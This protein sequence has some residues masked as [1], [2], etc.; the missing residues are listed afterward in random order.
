MSRKRERERGNNRLKLVFSFKYALKTVEGGAVVKIKIK[1]LNFFKKSIPSDK[2]TP[3]RHHYVFFA[4]N[5]LLLERVDNV[6]F[7]EALE[8]KSQRPVVSA[9]DELDAAKAADA[10][11]GHHVQV[12]QSD[13][14]VFRDQ[15]GRNATVSWTAADGTGA[16]R[17]ATRLV[18]V[19]LGSQFTQI[20][21]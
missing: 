7:L 6:L 1:N 3:T 16:G 11:R 15:L 10:Q 5:V 13:V 14:S 21:N 18:V 9:L 17:E 8:G 19:R 20:S 4:V 2:R 12:G